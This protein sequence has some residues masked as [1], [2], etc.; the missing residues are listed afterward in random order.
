VLD[1]VRDLLAR[2]VIE[3]SEAS[4]ATALWVV[5]TWLID[6]LTVSPVM[7]ITAPD[8]GA[9]KSV[10][11]TAMGRLV[12]RPLQASNFTAAAMSFM[13]DAYC[14]TVLI[15]EA[16]LVLLGNRGLR[17]MINGGHTRGSA[18][19]VKMVN[20]APRRLSTWCPKAIAGIG[21]QADTLT[22]RSIVIRLERKLATEQVLNL[23]H[24]DPREFES[25]GRKLARLPLDFGEQLAV[26]RPASVVGLSDRARDNW[27]PLLAI[28]DIAGGGW[29]A[30]ARTAAEKLSAPEYQEPSPQQLLLADIRGVFCELSVPNI[31]TKELLARLTQ[32]ADSPWRSFKG[33]KL[34]ERDL[35]SL[36]GEYGISPGTRRLN[37][38]EGSSG[39]AKGYKRAA[40][41]NAF[42]RYL[43]AIPVAVIHEDEAKGQDA[44]VLTGIP[45]PLRAA[46]VPS[47][48]VKKPVMA[49]IGAMV[50]SV[51]KAPR[52]PLQSDAENK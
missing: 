24:A 52:K 33:R 46:S 47:A 34:T 26:H 37:R 27:E 3:S 45:L 39:T 42:L 12:R 10:K 30:R 40:L 16:D 31:S 9:G 7:M 15:D 5:M 51:R 21:R 13:V 20:G 44:E 50:T 38:S 8:K 19:V 25:V 17:S 49:D 1:L 35:A 36:L 23:R 2:Y 28:A 41:E 4:D 14:P 18:S 32:M 22:D 48:Q 43:P 29:P 11:L 6:H